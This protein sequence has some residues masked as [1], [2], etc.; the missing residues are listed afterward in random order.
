MLY[1]VPWKWIRRPSTSHKETKVWKHKAS[2]RTHRSVV[3]LILPISQFAPLYPIPSWSCLLR[4]TML[5]SFWFKSHADE[6]KPFI[7]HTS[8][9]VTW[10]LN[11]C[12]AALLNFFLKTQQTLLW[13]PSLQGKIWTLYNEIWNLNKIIQNFSHGLSSQAHCVLQTV[14]FNIKEWVLKSA[15]YHFNYSSEMSK[16]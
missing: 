1:W 7:F 4:K 10:A 13:I 12:F 14:L 16:E 8:E 6:Q 11:F 5:Q 15:P 2:R 9:V 3:L